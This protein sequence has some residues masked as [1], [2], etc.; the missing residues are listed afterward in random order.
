MQRTRLVLALGCDRSSR[1]ASPRVRPAR[2]AIAILLVAAAPRL[3]GSLAHV[4]AAVTGRVVIDEHVLARLLGDRSA[5]VRELAR[6]APLVAFG[7]INIRPTGA[8]VASA[9][10]VGRLAGR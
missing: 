6:T 3:W 4:Y 8:I 10:A 9:E 7:L 5:V 1:D 2:D